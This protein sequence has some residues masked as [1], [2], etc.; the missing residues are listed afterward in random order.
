M[1]KLKNL[2]GVHTHTHTHTSRNLK[3]EERVVKSYSKN[4]GNR[5]L[6]ETYY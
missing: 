6:L 1:Q 2:A 4:N 3:E 5:L